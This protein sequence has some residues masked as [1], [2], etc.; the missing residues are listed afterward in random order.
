MKKSMIA[1]ATAGLMASAVSSA[2]ADD[3]TYVSGGIYDIGDSDIYLEGSMRLNPNLVLSAQYTDAAEFSLYGGGKYFVDFGQSQ[4]V[5]TFI[6]AG[7]SHY[8]FSDGPDFSAGDDTG[9]YAG[10]GFTTKFDQYSRF[11][12]DARYDTVLDGFF[13]V[14]ARF[15]YEFLDRLSG[16]VGYRVNTSGMDNEVRVG[17]TYSF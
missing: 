14:G 2:Q 12:V 9:V 4:D 1:L 5:E 15:R 10:A 13:S 8:D 3:F 16:D 7:V 6:Q 17:L 11:I